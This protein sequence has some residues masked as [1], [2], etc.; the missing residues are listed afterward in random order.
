MANNKLYV[1]SLANGPLSNGGVG[2]TL[3]YNARGGQFVTETY[4][5]EQ[6]PASVVRV[7]NCVDE[8]IINANAGEKVT[9]A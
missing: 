2:R 9:G 7:R 3:A 5:T 6:P 1:A 8:I 4:R